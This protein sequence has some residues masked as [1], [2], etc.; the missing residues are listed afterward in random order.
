MALLTGRLPPLRLPCG[1]AW[2]FALV[3]A[4]AMEPAAAQGRTVSG[5]Y[6]LKAAFI[7]RIAGFIEWPRK[8]ADTPLRLCVLGGNPFGTALEALRSKTVQGRR[9]ELVYPESI[10]PLRD[11]HLLFVSPAAEK[12]LDRVIALSRDA[13]IFTIG[14]GAGHARRGIM[15]NFY[16]DGDRVRFEM[17]LEAV[18]RSG[19]VVSSKLLSLA[20][21]VDA[22]PFGS[23]P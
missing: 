19:L 22:S 7:Y 5:E 17:N 4:L 15:L 23:Q 1:A 6:E 14:D 2:A 18:R 10:D 3:L 9:L 16:L 8:S 21:I 11:C 20:R 12:H 13:G